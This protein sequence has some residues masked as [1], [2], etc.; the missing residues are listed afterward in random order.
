[1]AQLTYDYRDIESSNSEG[2]DLDEL[3]D[4]K[5]RYI[6]HSNDTETDSYNPSDRF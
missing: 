1:M 5:G 6:K 4:W 3:E 2:L